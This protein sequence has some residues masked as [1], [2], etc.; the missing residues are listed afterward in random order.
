[1]SDVGSAYLC[2]V[3]PTSETGGVWGLGISQHSEV[4]EGSKI[5]THVGSTLLSAVRK[6]RGG[7]YRVKKKGGSERGAG[8]LALRK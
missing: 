8:G 4:W 5:G 7:T 2:G 1:M 6:G 3:G